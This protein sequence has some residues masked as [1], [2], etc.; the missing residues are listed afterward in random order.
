LLRFYGG[1][2]CAEISRDLDVPIGTVTKHLSRAYA[3][4]RETLPRPQQ[5][6]D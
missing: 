4:L 2:T 1:L 6:E 5:T 3:V